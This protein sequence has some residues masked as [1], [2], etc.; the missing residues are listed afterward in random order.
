[1]SRVGQRSVRLE[2]EPLLKV[3]CNDDLGIREPAS[4]EGAVGRDILVHEGY[5]DALDQVID[6][7]ATGPG[8]EPAVLNDIVLPDDFRDH[9]APVD[10]VGVVSG[11]VELGP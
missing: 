3:A 7:L 11:R 8:R 5:R 9:T 4:A 1:M 2:T 10:H 6:Q